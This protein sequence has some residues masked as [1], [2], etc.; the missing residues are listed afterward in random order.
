MVQEGGGGRGRGG[1]FVLLVGDGGVLRGILEY[2]GTH[3]LPLLVVPDCCGT[4]IPK[5]L[6]ELSLF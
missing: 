4:E 5:I 3:F 6:F 2:P 1:K